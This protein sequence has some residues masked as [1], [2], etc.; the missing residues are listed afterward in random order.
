VGKDKDLSKRQ[1]EKA[2][3]WAEEPHANQRK[4]N[5]EYCEHVTG[6]RA[7]ARGGK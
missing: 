7:K 6:G 2:R 4:F 1:E 3:F 5:V